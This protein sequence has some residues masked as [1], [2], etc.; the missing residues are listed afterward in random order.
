MFQKSNLVYIA[1]DAG[2]PD[3]HWFVDYCTD[4][5]AELVWCRGTENYC[6]PNDAQY[7]VNSFLAHIQRLDESD[8]GEAVEWY[9]YDPYC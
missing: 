6:C 5:H 4:Y 3:I 9:D 8:P 7:L 2:I 1:E